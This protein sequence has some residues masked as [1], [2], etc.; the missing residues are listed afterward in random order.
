VI[1]AVEV[2]QAGVASGINN[3]VASVAELL[4]VAIFGAVALAVFNHALDQHIASR[5]MSADVVQALSAARGKFVTDIAMT[6]LHGDP[7]SRSSVS[8]LRERLDA[9]LAPLVKRIRKV[10]T[11]DRAVATSKTFRSLARLTGA[12]P[13]TAGPRVRRSLTDVGLRQLIAFVS[14]MTS[15]DLAELEGVSAS[16]AHQLVAGALVAEAGMR[17]LDLGE[18]EI[19]PWALREGVILRRLDHTD[20][21]TDETE[22]NSYPAGGSGRTGGRT[23]PHG[24]R[25]RR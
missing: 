2:R 12:A 1:N 24:A 16:R 21:Q 7:P 3:A 8:E 20:G 25:W 15:A 4:A 5:A 18:L 19:C 9:E 23:E 10:G 14:R 6:A 11:P 13:S 17:A 22:N